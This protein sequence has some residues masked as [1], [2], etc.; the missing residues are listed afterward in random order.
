MGSG[1]GRGAGLHTS[2]VGLVRDFTP[3]D[4]ASVE[5]AL[6]DL[7][8]LGVRE[9]RTRVSW[10][11]A[12]TPE[13][14]TWYR[15]LMQR[16][17]QDVCVL[18]CLVGTP[19]GLGR[20]GRANAPPAEP[21]AFGEF[22]ERF[23]SEHG[24]SVEWV[25]LWDEPRNL[26]LYDWRLDPA[27][28]TFTALVAEGALR[29]HAAGKRVVLGGMSPVDPQW[30]DWLLG[31]LGPDMLDAVGVHGWPDTHDTPWTGWDAWL[32]P[33]RD[34]LVRHA[35]RAEVWITAAGFSTWH[36]RE[37][38]QVA[39]FLDAAAA[40]VTRT[41]WDGL[42]DACSVED[43]PEEGTDE[44]DLYL[45]LK[46]ADGTPKLLYRLWAESGLVGLAEGF[47]RL[48]AARGVRPE[49][50]V[51][52]FGGAGFIGCN[53]ANAYLEEG[54][55]V[56]V[57]DNLSRTGVEKNLRW[58]R[59]RHGDRLDVEVADIRD[60]AS[61]RR[62]VRHAGEVFHFGAQVA[63]TT[64][65]DAPTHDFEVNARGTFNVLEA[66]RAMD[67]PAPLVFTSTNKVYGGL[68]GQRFVAGERR[69]EPLD[70]DIRAQGI[71]ERC[72]L[73]FESPYGCSKGTADQYVLDWARSYGLR[74]TVFRMSCIFGP[75]QFGTEDQ[76]WVA[77][78]LIRVLKRQ[79]ITLYGDGRQ[80]RDL[81]FVEDLVRAF[82]LAQVKMDAVSGQVFNIGG[83]PTRAV[84]LL[85]LLALIEE[86]VGRAPDVRHEDWRAGDQRYYVSDTRKFQAATGWAPQVGVREGVTRLLGWLDERTMPRESL[87]LETYAG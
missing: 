57:Y 3:G 59:E 58:L 63:V 29:A 20:L 82:R 60:A 42:V 34:V 52:V 22:V 18:P 73:D 45:G 62:A 71:S 54:R 49:R 25:E 87:A 67:T 50:Q 40:P 83:G 28:E 27:W 6:A 86:L 64:S 1:V 36:H 61:V 9:L 81:L 85:E 80:V 41:Y 8:V 47:R 7:K 24:R 30:L 23:L 77:H 37:R 78:F 21:R 43:V 31:R 14:A 33:V 74:A 10:A 72:A 26:T 76:G 48:G 11:H 39:E 16:L 4:H 32:E 51:V 68:P 55:R 69:Y 56:L 13:G 12:V 66:L 65:L 84:S 35:S 5:A 53:V 19:P 15:G 79:P 75:R 2:R 38:R 46:R 70:P 44:R 17:S